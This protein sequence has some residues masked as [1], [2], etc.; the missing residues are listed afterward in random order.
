MIELRE[1]CE[2]IARRVD[3]TLCPVRI[4]PVHNADQDVY[5][6]Y[7]RPGIVGVVAGS[8][9][10]FTLVMTLGR[11]RPALRLRLA[12][13]VAAVEEKWFGE[14]VDTGFGVSIEAWDRTMAEMERES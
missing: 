7:V 12:M 14:P 1:E 3:L 5:L 9:S 8:Q 10:A 11:M 4:D 2:K 13:A 6:A